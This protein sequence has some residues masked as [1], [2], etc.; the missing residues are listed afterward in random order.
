MVGSATLTMKKSVIGRNT[1]I[2]TTASPK[3][4]SLGAS[5]S[6][7]VAGSGRGTVGVAIRIAMEPGCSDL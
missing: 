3:A 1:P 7:A 4:L 6:G 5:V 2:R